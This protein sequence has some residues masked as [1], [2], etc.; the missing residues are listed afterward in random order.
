[1][2]R[3]VDSCVVL[4]VLSYIDISKDRLWTFLQSIFS[5]WSVSIKNQIKSRPAKKSMN[6]NLSHCL[7]SRSGVLRT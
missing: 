1:M 5:F 4:V 6:P 7:C 3:R 2:V